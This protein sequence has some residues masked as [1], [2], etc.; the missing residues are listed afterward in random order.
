M[1]R[2]LV[3]RCLGFIALV[4]ITSTLLGLT[5]ANLPG[6]FDHD[7]AF[8]L[9][10]EPDSFSQ[11]FISTQKR[12]LFMVL[13]LSWGPS[14]LTPDVLARDMLFE[15]FWRSL[16][17][18]FGAM[19]IAIL[20]SIFLALVMIKFKKWQRWVQELIDI[21]QA[22]PYI[23]L[24]PLALWLLPVAWYNQPY[25]FQF[26][27]VFNLMAIKPTL[28]L[29]QVLVYSL[30]QEQAKPYARTWF[31]MGGGLGGFY[32]KWLLPNILVPIVQMLPQ[33]LLGFISGS[34]LLE[35]LFNFPGMGYLFIESLSQRDWT[36][37][38]PHIFLLSIILFLSQLVADLLSFK[39][40]PRLR[41][42]AI[43]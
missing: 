25:F 21:G 42:L 2:Y 32:F 4:I 26:I 36:I 5:E 28:M 12:Y 17:V 31:G 29:A 8:V 43:A 14:Q 20:L 11:N 27:F 23:F 41:R 34:I 19:V 6:R 40:D 35:T 1:G 15:H 39:I 9:E 3:I 7:E 18:L 22:I 16:Q 24:I 38:G 37:L 13:G 10:P 33:L 30:D